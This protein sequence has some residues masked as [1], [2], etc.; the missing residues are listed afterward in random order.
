MSHKNPEGVARGTIKRAINKLTFD[1]QVS[2]MIDV[3]K[4]MRL[5]SFAHMMEEAYQET[6]KEI[7]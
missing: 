5:Q 7:A 6:R 4:S 3:L 1:Q 2:V